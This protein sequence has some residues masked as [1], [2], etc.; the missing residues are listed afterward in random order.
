MSALIQTGAHVLELTR[1]TLL[2]LYDY[3]TVTPL[4]ASKYA[5]CVV[6]RRRRRIVFLTDA[7]H[8]P[9]TDI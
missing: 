2:T 9:R 5:V 4:V 1:E 6:H 8:R 7:D 3:V